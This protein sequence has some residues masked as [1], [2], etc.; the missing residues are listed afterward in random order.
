MGA[1]RSLVTAPLALAALLVVGAC[2]T[3]DVPRA[4]DQRRATPLSDPGTG[5]AAGGISGV[6]SAARPPA[7][8]GAG[9]EAG[10][11]RPLVVFLGDSL[12]AGYGL[13]AEEAYPAHVERLLAERGLPVRVL[14]AGVSGDTS[15][16]GRERLDWF[17]AQRPALVVVEL[18]GNDGLRGQPLAATEANLRAIVERSLAAGARVVLAGMR[19]PTNYGAEY[20]SGFEAIFPRLAAAY[21]VPLIPFLLAG[22][23]AD[24]A[25]NLPDGIH[26]NAE[27]QRIVAAT[28]AEALAPLV[29]ELAESTARTAGSH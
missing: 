19:I 21:D 27:G 22:V 8:P 24:P 1:M 17:L 11:R 25:L 6:E 13:S 12:T 28:V 18:G 5:A 4:R 16:G 2:N 9:D 3:P 29:A 14:N 15:A 7:A 20:G 23:A 26:P 10:D